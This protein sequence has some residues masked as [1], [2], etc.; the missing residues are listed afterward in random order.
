M[1]PG[2]LLKLIIFICNGIAQK[3]AFRKNYNTAIDISFHAFLTFLTNEHFL[4]PLK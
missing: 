1:S 4:A 3:V 2:N